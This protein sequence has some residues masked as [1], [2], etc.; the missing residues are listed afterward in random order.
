MY[1]ILERCTGLTGYLGSLTTCTRPSVNHLW[2]LIFLRRTVQR[3]F[4][5]VGWILLHVLIDPT[6]TQLKELEKSVPKAKGIG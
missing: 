2:N 5:Q 1:T 3:D 4:Y 6:S